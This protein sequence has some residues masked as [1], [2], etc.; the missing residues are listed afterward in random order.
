MSRKERKTSGKSLRTLA[1]F[2]LCVSVII[3]ISLSIK[4]FA[5]I[6]ASKFDGTHRF[7]VAVFDKEK[8]I[9][10]LSFD[11]KNK[12]I[13]ALT[14]K[15]TNITPQNL[16][17]TLATAVDATVT[18]KKNLKNQDP[19]HKL[20]NLASTFGAVAT[21]TTML[22]LIRL[23]LLANTI[24]AN[25]I[26]K[27]ILTIPSAESDIDAIS[28]QLFND[29]T[30][31]Q[32]GISIEIINATGTPGLGRRLERAVNN[33]GGRV[34]AVTTAQK[35]EA[36]SKI[37]FFG[38]KSYT[39]K[40]LEMMLNTAEGGEQAR[41]QGIADLQIILGQDSLSKTTF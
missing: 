1:L 17:K 25:K 27:E 6:K 20:L 16:S 30:V 12:T 14:V 28:S 24:P 37:K 36:L 41:R 39:L 31:T 2:F 5:V 3:L 8:N 34:I 32:E 15:G 18:M 11:P 40:K 19:T 4:L 33:M 22:D 29:P 35:M 38:E 9:D 21:N 26:T 23:S 10:V 13:S 7:T